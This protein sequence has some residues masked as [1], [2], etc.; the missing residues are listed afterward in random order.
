MWCWGAEVG[1]C[2][3]GCASGG[4]KVIPKERVCREAEAGHAV[5]R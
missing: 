4:T 2:A 3:F 5:V 1:E